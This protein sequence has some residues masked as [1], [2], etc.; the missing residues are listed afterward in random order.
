MIKTILSILAMGVLIVA[1]GVVVNEGL[2]K[3]ERVECQQWVR[4]SQQYQGWYST[5]WQKQQCLSYG[6]ELK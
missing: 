4:D 2:K 6:I 3:T 5:E 1:F